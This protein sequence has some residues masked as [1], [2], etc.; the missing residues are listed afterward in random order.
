MVYEISMSHDF[1]LTL[2]NITRYVNIDKKRLMLKCMLYTITG[3]M[4]NPAACLQ[5]F[6]L[7]TAET[8]ELES[9]YFSRASSMYV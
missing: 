5:L 6:D 3:S 1:S 9:C 8:D 2:H 4:H 7:Q